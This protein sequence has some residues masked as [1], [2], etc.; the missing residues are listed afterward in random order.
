MALETY[1]MWVGGKEVDGQ[2]DQ[3]VSFPS[4]H[5]ALHV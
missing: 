5:D 4:A 3:S 2:A 1:K